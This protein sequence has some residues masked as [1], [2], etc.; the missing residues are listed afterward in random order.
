MNSLLFNS[1]RSSETVLGHSQLAIQPRLKV[2]VSTVP[3]GKHHPSRHRLPTAGP[4]GHRRLQTH[5]CP[6]GVTSSCVF[7]LNWF[8]GKSN[9][10]TPFQ[11][12]TPPPHTAQTDWPRHTTMEEER[13]SD[14]CKY[15]FLIAISFT[16]FY[17]NQ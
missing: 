2:G 6:P 11:D 5:T 16:C 14:R 7:A 4:P 10:H 9:T 12:P 1:F 17:R 8:A 13:W 3:G 15:V